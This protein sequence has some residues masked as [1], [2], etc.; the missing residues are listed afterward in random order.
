MCGNVFQSHTCE[1]PSHLLPISS[2][3]NTQQKGK[4]APQPLDSCDCCPLFI[5]AVEEGLWHCFSTAITA[6]SIFFYHV[7]SFICFFGDFLF[8]CFLF[9][10]SNVISLYALCLSLN[11][12]CDFSSGKA[13]SSREVCWLFHVL[14]FRLKNSLTEYFLPYFFLFWS[15]FPSAKSAKCWVSF[16]VFLRPTFRTVIYLCQYNLHHEILS[17]VTP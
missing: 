1:I 10:S 16:F 5:P 3:H 4:K 15:Y 12:S 7:N 13:I 6:L 14:P 9:Q 11:C 2:G 17:L 8:V